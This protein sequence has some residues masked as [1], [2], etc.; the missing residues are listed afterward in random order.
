VHYG[1]HAFARTLYSGKCT[2]AHIH[3][4]GQACPHAPARGTTN[5]NH[6]WAD[7]ERKTRWEV[8]T[9]DNDE[10]NNRTGNSKHTIHP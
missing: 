10:H 5:K 9:I 1:A 7:G 2:H 4:H 8:F 6:T 3:A